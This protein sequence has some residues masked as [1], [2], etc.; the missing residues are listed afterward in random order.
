[1]IVGFVASLVALFP[2]GHKHA[3]QVAETQPE[4]FAAFEG[5]YDS[6]RP[7]EMVIFGLVSTTPPDEPRLKAKVEVPGL[8]SWLL[9]GDENA[10]IEGLADF[11][12][13]EVPRG[14]ELWLTFVSFHNMFILG[15]IFIG[16]TAL[17]VLLIWR[18]K[19]L[20]TGSFVPKWW[21]RAMVLVTPLPVAA[22]EFGWV[23]AEVGR[24]PW[25]VYKLLRTEDAASPAVSADEILFSIL[26]FGAIYLLL[27]AVWLYLLFKKVRKGPEPA[28]G[29]AEGE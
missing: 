14:T 1:V 16:M 26:M 11:P 18:R 28:P 29:A 21:L 5:L 3:E 20:D 19:I 25:I 6:A 15:M 24:Q 2:T 23:A 9:K 10:P 12:A 27:G 17:G 4:K 7:R 13:D 22:C 8:L